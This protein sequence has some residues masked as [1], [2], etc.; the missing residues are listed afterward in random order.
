MANMTGKE[1]VSS[2]LSGFF[3]GEEDFF[4]G[5]LE[6]NGNDIS[7]TS[8]SSVKPQ[9]ALSQVVRRYG[10]LNEGTQ[11]IPTADKSAFKRRYI[12]RRSLADLAGL[13]EGFE[14]QHRLDE[15]HP[16]AVI[17]LTPPNMVAVC[18]GNGLWERRL[19]Q[20]Q[21]GPPPYT[22]EWYRAYLRDSNLPAWFLTTG[23]IDMLTNDIEAQLLGVADTELPPA[24]QVPASYLAV[25]YPTFPQFPKLVGVG[26]FQPY[27]YPLTDHERLCVARQFPATNLLGADTRILILP[28]AYIQ[29]HYDPSS[30]GC[31]VLN[32]NN[33]RWSR[34]AASRASYINKKADTV[35]LSDILS[36]SVDNR[37]G[38]AAMKS[39]NGGFV[40]PSERLSGLG[41]W[42][43]LDADV[44]IP[45]A[46]VLGFQQPSDVAV[47]VQR[48]HLRTGRAE[49][50]APSVVWQPDMRYFNPDVEPAEPGIWEFLSDA[51][52]EKARDDLGGQDA[53]GLA[54]SPDPNAY[55]IWQIRQY[56]KL[57]SADSGS[58]HDPTAEIDLVWILAGPGEAA[59]VQVAGPVVAGAQEEPTAPTPQ[60]QPV[61]PG[62]VDASHGFDNTTGLAHEP[63]NHG[64]NNQ[65]ASDG[66][67]SYSTR[68]INGKKITLDRARAH[69]ILGASTP[70]LHRLWTYT[71]CGKWQ[72]YPETGG[73]IDWAD[74][75]SVEKLNKWRQQSEKRNQWA[76]KRVLPR[77]QYTQ[78]QRAWVFGFVEENGG[79]RPRQG[80]AEL[81]RQFNE[82]FGAQ[83]QQK[84]IE[85]FVDRMMKEYKA[86]GGKMKT[87]AERAPKKR[88]TKAEQAKA[89]HEEEDEDAPHESE[90]DVEIVSF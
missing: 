86:N 78:E 80:G 40:N 74:K 2:T 15:Q 36:P 39:N 52:R 20:M 68:L 28:G 14:F 43:W 45:A 66:R 75:V 87:K 37:S 35:S 10:H 41:A 55:E 89:E 58:Q 83:R 32:S 33:L 76:P 63:L 70:Q 51:A 84:A 71:N 46:Q 31:P 38:L 24:R 1:K 4:C 6:E 12:A 11:S 3:G 59:E 64:E 8:P 5:L 67:G 30:T 82:K 44:D 27:Q 81:C 34:A 60:I 50:D 21:D 56:F 69:P 23:H 7:N 49:Y 65:T 29:I 9:P 26:H 79:G 16:R 48:G 90:S 62:E 19:R 47:A 54:D 57:F 61:I 85:G 22:P 13:P 53:F 73:K 17:L 18:N 42:E 72:R 77:E 25:R 88:K